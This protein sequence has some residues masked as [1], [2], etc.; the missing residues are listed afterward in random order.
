MLSHFLFKDDENCLHQSITDATKK[1]EASTH[2]KI[3]SINAV[4]KNDDHD[5]SKK[6]KIAERIDLSKMLATVIIGVVF[7]IT[8]V[9]LGIKWLRQRT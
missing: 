7:L 1:F 6:K 2:F 9:G 4:K 3:I 8:A 5:D